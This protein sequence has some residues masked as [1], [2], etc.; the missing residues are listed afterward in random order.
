M[1]SHYVVSG[2]SAITI[3]TASPTSQMYDSKGA[4]IVKHGEKYS[5]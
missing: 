3:I 1:P 2:S 5:H 4:K